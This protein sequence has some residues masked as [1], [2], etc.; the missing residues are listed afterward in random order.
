MHPSSRTRAALAAVAVALVAACAHPRQATDRPP[1]PQEQRS[2]EKS[3][4]AAPE[5]PPVP[6]SPQGLLAPDAV[7]ELQEALAARGFLRE[8]RKGEL[9]DATSKAV[10]EF[11]RSQN[12]AETGFPDRETM[13]R[14]GLDPTKEY[15]KDNAG[16]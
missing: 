2:K 6:A 9:D 4:K 11:Q 15:G 13:E 3:V 5:R 8:H 16:K 7:G 10:R 12:L 14:L 1:E